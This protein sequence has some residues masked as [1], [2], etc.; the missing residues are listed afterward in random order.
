MKE[1]E[2]EV[3]KTLVASTAHL[4]STI[5]ITNIM[6]NDAF[7][8]DEYEYG[9]RIWIG[10]LDFPESYDL[11]DLGYSSGFIEIVDLASQNDCNWIKFDAD[12]P[13]YDGLITYN[14]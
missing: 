14:W 11:V 7:I 3:E 2:L 9:I 8:V 4:A 1:L 10:S 13:I 12:G 6:S 5:E